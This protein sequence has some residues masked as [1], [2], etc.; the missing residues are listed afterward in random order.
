MPGGLLKSGFRKIYLV[1]CRVCKMRFRFTGLSTCSEEC[2]AKAMGRTEKTISKK[3]VKPF[4]SARTSK[5]PIEKRSKRKLR[6]KISDL[7]NQI[8]KLRGQRK[9]K[10]SFYTSDE[11]QALRYQAIKRYGRKCMACGASGVEIHVDHIK[12]RSKHPELEL[13][14]TNLQVLCR[15]CNMGKSNKDDTDWRSPQNINP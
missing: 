3:E 6:N 9:P 8:A 10:T 1:T 15:P 4:Y 2:F 13:E 5:Q 14:I 7:E 11:W 12:P